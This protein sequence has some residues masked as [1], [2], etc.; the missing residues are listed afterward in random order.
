MNLKKK[1]FVI[2]LDAFSHNYLSEKNTP[3]LWTLKDKGLFGKLKSELMYFPES[4]SLTGEKK[5]KLSKYIFNQNN[6]TIKKI[7]YPKYMPN[8]L[9]KHFKY[10]NL[11]DQK[12]NTLF[13]IFIKNKILFLNLNR[14]L[15]K[16]KFCLIKN[17]MFSIFKTGEKK[18]INIFRKEIIHNN[19]EFVFISLHK[20]DL[21]GHK[22]GPKSSV[23]FKEL[24]SIDTKIKILYKQIINNYSEFAL[25]IFSDHGMMKVKKE[26]NLIKYLEKNNFKQPRDF[27]SFIDSISIRF[28]IKDK[29][30]LKKIKTLLS[31]IKDGE[32]FDNNR[33]E[34][35]NI[36]NEKEIIGDILFVVKPGILIMPNYFQGKKT[37]KGMH[38]YNYETTTKQDAIFM[39]I[40]P[41]IKP[42][43]ISKVLFSN[44]TP[45][46]LAYLNIE[47]SSNMKTKSLL[48]HE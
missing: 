3:F 1:M 43:K 39:M 15:L 33:L 20:L 25:M 6:D 24:R 35:L 45:T 16:K 18:L 14:H 2:M 42:K 36:P 44:I 8:N 38:G 46:I 28:W 47:P 13:N 30:K 27:I 7:E 11:Y 9:K 40:G 29:N 34:K 17:L 4:M 23:L 22:Y 48:K 32:I 31:E 12:E 10:V 5:N 37:I 26:I 21:L 19:Y 41:Q